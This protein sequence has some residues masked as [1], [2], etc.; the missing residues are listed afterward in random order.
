MKK[1]NNIEGIIVGAGQAEFTL[2]DTHK[3]SPA[4]LAPMLAKGRDDAEKK[5]W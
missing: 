1:S 5:R 4:C 3:L 2:S